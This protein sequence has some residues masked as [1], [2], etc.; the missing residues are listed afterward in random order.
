M[1][2][3]Y[4][5]CCDKHINQK[6]KQKHIK[7]K[8]HLNMYYNI[9]TNIYNN[10]D[11]YWTD[12]ET[13]IQEYIKD[14]STK[15]YAFTILVR[16]KLNN[17]DIN[18]S[19]DGD[20]GCVPLYKFEDGTWFYYNYFKSKQIRDYIFHRAMLSSIKLDSFSIISNVTITFFSKY[21]TKTGKHR[22]EQPRRVLE[23]KLL[24]HIKNASYDDKIIKYN[25]LSLEYELLF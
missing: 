4:C 8:A 1:V 3:N 6:Y 13:T 18:F 22:F 21:K 19:V 14:N 9:V 7:S 17:E 25:F 2:S 5:Q 20:K 15:I 11:V 16:C 23:S 12:I 24:K 10:G